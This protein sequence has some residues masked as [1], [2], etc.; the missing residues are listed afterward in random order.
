LKTVTKF[1][2]WTGPKHFCAGMF[3]N[4]KIFFFLKTQV[5]SEIIL[6]KIFQQGKSWDSLAFLDLKSW[7]VYA[8]NE[9]L[10]G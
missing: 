7:N 3:T 4:I 8:E 5:S 6:L 2:L 10:S 9:K 1:F